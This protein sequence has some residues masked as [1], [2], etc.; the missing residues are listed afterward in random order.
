MIIRIIAALYIIACS[1]PDL[2]YLYAPVSVSAL[3]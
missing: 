3:N 2:A 1:A